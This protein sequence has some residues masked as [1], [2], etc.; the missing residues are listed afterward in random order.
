LS[1]DEHEST[2]KHFKLFKEEGFNGADS[3]SAPLN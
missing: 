2:S 1:S 3:L